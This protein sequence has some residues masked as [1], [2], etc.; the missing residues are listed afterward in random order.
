MYTNSDRQ[1]EDVSRNHNRDVDGSKPRRDTDYGE[2]YTI[3]PFPFGQLWRR[4]L[5]LAHERFLRC[6]EGCFKNKLAN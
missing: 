5:E 6:S 4:D 3:L 1:R 2:V